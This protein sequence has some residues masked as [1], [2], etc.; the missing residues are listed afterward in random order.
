MKENET[1]GQSAVVLFSG[2]QDS[3]TCLYW[4]KTQFKKVYALGF[5]Y[6]QRHAVELEQ[7]R[8]IAGK[9]GVH[10]ELL[11]LDIIAH[12]GGNALTDSTK[13]IAPQ[14]PQN[15]ELPNTFVPGRNLFFLNTAAAWAYQRG[16]HNIVGGMC[17]EDYSG[18]PDCRL[19]FMQAMQTALQRG[20]D[21]PFVL[22]TPLMHL[23][24]AATWQLAEEIGCKE[25]I[26]N[27]THT[28]Y[29][30][31]RE[32]LH[33]WGYGCGECPACVLRKRGYQQAFN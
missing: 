25:I 33:P 20:M 23:D 9:A 11:P 15:P 31:V 29:E 26:I 13:S 16:I 27:D 12:L 30:G 17:E 10:Y 1:S 4:A 18:Y 8:K 7:A 32:T 24:K 2:G 28:C 22:H 14:S 21:A 6:G 3:T 19:N 5:R